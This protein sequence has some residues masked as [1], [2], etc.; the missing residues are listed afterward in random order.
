MMGPP[1]FGLVEPRR[2]TI[3]TTYATKGQSHQNLRPGEAAAHSQDPQAG[4]TDRLC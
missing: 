4:S 3:E 2:C 1:A